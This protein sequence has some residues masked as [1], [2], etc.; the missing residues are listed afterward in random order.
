MQDYLWTKCKNV[1]NNSSWIVY[2][3]RKDIK[4]N[5]PSSLSQAL[6]QSLRRSQTAGQ[7]EG[8]DLLHH[9]PINLS[10]KYYIR[11]VY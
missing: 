11:H 7:W 2:W 5:N 8:S 9:M 4:L 1:E 6:D 10:A 3:E